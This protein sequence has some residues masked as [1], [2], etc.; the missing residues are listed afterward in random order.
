M[1]TS[2]TIVTNETINDTT[3][4]NLIVANDTEGIKNLI[5]DIDTAVNANW[6]I[7]EKNSRTMNALKVAGFEESEQYKQLSAAN[8][9]IVG[10]N[11]RYNE[12]RRKAY[13]ALDEL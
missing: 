12:I 2:I 1:N 5:Q 3:L 8:K 6:E 13:N 11:Y 7:S 4:L 9:D 10:T